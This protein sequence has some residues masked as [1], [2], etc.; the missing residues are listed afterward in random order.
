METTLQGGVERKVKSLTTIV[1]TLGCERFGT[2]KQKKQGNTRQPNRREH[3]I[4]K[5]RRELRCLRN[6]FRRSN[7]TER[8]GLQQLRDDLRKQLKS[9]RNAENTRRKRR[10]AAKKRAINYY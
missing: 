10:E 9:I 2:E 3:Q 5:L 1:Y 6:W 8:I 7:I 4:S